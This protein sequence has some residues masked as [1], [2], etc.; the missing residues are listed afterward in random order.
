MNCFNAADCVAVSDYGGSFTAAVQK[1][2][3]FATQFHPE[4]SQCLGLR[5]LENFIEWE[6]E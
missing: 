2:N 3:I 5:V 1:D 4:K 6:V